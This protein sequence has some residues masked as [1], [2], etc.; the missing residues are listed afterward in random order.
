M[1]PS[2]PAPPR[3]DKASLPDP[4]YHWTTLKAQVFLGALSDLGRVG[5][6]ARA[7]GMSRQSAY[8]LRERLGE[9]RCSPAHETTL[10]RRGA[11]SAGRSGAPRAGRHAWR[12]KATFSGSA[13][14]GRQI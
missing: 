13:D 8:K 9:A 12:P 5:D 3:P 1:S 2:T 6:A 7:V 11:R 10:R 14:D 4:S